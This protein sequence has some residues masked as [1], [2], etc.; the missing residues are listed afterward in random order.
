M[1]DSAAPVHQSD[2][3]AGREPARTPRQLASAVRQ[4]TC[5]AGTECYNAELLIER[6]DIE[7]VRACVERIKA[8]LVRAEAK[9]ALAIEAERG[10]CAAPTRE[11]LDWIARWARGWKEL[12]ADRSLDHYYEQLPLEVAVDMILELTE[13]QRVVA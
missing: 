3:D 5:T 8:A 4:D 7:G 10:C 13:A 6:G 1:N 12:L 11:R 9:M 2:I